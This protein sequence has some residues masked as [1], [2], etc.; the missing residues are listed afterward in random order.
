MATH[1]LTADE[2]DLLAFMARETDEGA[3]LAR[4]RELKLRGHTDRDG[5]IRRHINLL[6]AR[7]DA[8]MVLEQQRRELDRN[9][10]DAMKAADGAHWDRQRAQE[11]LHQTMVELAQAAGEDQ[12]AKYELGGKPS[13]L[14]GIAKIIETGVKIADSGGDGGGMTPDERRANAKAAGL[15]D[16][17][18]VVTPVVPPHSDVGVGKA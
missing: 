11:K 2:R 10:I 16:E 4:Y 6:R 3:W 14:A 8:K 12:L 1:S 18:P 17:T 13:G 7:P 5:Q 15:I 9:R